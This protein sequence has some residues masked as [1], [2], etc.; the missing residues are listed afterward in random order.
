MSILDRLLKKTIFSRL[1][2][3]FI[4]VLVPMYM[5]GIAMYNWSINAVR[6]EIIKS[7]EAQTT[8][9]LKGLETEI[10]RIKL[11][12]YDCLNDSNLNHLASIPESLDEIQKMEYILALQKT[13]QA[14]ERSSEYIKD[15]TALIPAI[16]KKIA[17]IDGVRGLGEEEYNKLHY[18]TSNSKEQ[19][20]SYEDE[21]FLHAAYPMMGG[22]NNRKPLFVIKI[23]LS[24]QELENTVEQLNT[25]EGSTAMLLNNNNSMIVGNASEYVDN[26][27]KKNVVQRKERNLENTFS[28]KIEDK[29]YLVIYSSSNLLNMTLIKVIPENEIF[30]KLINIRNWFYLFTFLGISIIIIYSFST[31]RFIHKPIRNLVSA[32]K[33]IENGAFD[34]IVEYNHENEFKYLYHRFNVMVKNLKTLIDEVYMYKILSQKAELKQLQAQINPHF[35]YNSF[36]ILHRRIKGEEYDVALKFSQELG[37]YFKFITR[38][39]ADEVILSNEVDHALV[40]A[41]IQSMSFSSRIKVQFMELPSEYRNII[42]PRLILQPLLENS[43]EHGLK[44]KIEAGLL[45]VCYKK[46]NDI[47]QIIVEDNGTIDDNVIEELEMKIKSEDKIIENTGIVNIHKRLKLKFGDQGGVSILRSELG[48]LKLVLSI[49][50]I[51]CLDDQNA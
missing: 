46:E 13:L 31:Y 39:A 50:S 28:I 1:L 36:F 37:K 35:L 6:N 15:V 29:P 11:L 3:T 48:G 12:Q 14:I 22:K 43:F 16:G 9:Y 30:G 25:L 5:L 7:T 10:Q 41:E 8:F 44:D 26:E 4:C 27:V 40:Y 38:N 34:V 2:I 42:V 49:P 33:K 32:F 47:L 23:N 45:N 21:M 18:I 51:P 24:N 20:I 19:I 17:A